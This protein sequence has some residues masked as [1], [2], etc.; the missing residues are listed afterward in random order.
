MLEM[1]KQ[2]SSLSMHMFYVNLDAHAW[3]YKPKKLLI[4][5]STYHA[6]IKK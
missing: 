6:F 2:I 1:Y 4:R 5:V 3:V